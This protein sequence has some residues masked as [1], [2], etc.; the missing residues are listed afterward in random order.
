MDNDDVLPYEELPGEELPGEEL[1]GEELPG[2][3]SEDELQGDDDEDD[4][5]EDSLGIVDDEDE[6]TVNDDEEEEEEEEGDDD[7]MIPRN[8]NDIEYVHKYHPESI[9]VSFDTMYEMSIVTRNSDGII[10]DPSH[11]TLPILSKY[12]KTK[13]LGLRVNQLNKGAEPFVSGYDT[14]IDNNVIA[15][16]ELIE[17]KI[18]FIIKRPLPNGKSEYW[19][20]KDL[21]II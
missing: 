1:P 20:L 7:D 21:E 4:E 11:K 10:D 18:P 13:I 12:E 2:E 5:Y 9:P 6:P 8:V 16:Q 14:V 15:N 17:K 19:F 3:Y